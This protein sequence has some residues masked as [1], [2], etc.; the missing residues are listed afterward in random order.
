LFRELVEGEQSKAQRYI[1]FAEREAAKVPALPVD[2]KARPID[3]VAVVGAGTMGSGIAISVANAGIEVALIDA[4][5]EALQSG[6]RLMERHYEDAARRGRMSEDEATRRIVSITGSLTLES[7]ANAA[8]V[9]EAVFED[10]ELKQR[11]FS[12]LD[13]IARSEAILATNTS[14]LDIDEIAAATSRPDRIAGLHFFSPANVMRLV[15]IVRGKETAPEVVATL[16]SF[17]RRLGKIPV[18]VGNC[19]GFVGNRMLRRRNIAAERLLLQGA[20]PQEIDAAM[21]E[22]GFPM[23]PFAATDLAGLD[24]GW[25]MRKAIGARAEIA[26]ALCE[27]GRLGQKSGKGF[28]RYEPGSRSPLPDP[29]VE[30]LIVEASERLGIPRRTFDKAE[31]VER[32]LTPVIDEGRR[33]LEEGIAARASDIDVIWVHGYGWPVWRGGPMYYAENELK[34]RKGE[35]H[36]EKINA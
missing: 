10:L 32:L 22:F 11:I 31:I 5:E 20:L 25:R 33:I 29:E 14:Y 35:G 15:E 28:Y 9:V 34:Q 23:G 24:I 13:R 16:V 17:A 19:H 2:T 30:T 18:V 26:D 1:F 21:V 4:S 7:A 36:V 3:R 27:M 6:L 12:D 8:L